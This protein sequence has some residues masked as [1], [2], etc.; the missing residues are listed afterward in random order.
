MKKTRLFLIL[1]TAIGLLAGCGESAGTQNPATTGSTD[2]VKSQPASTTDQTATTTDKSVQP[3]DGS[4]T[5]VP[6]GNTAGNSYTLQDIAQHATPND[7]WMT[8]G[9]K[10]YDVSSYV[11]KHPGGEA[12]LQG[13]GIDATGMFQQVHTGE[14]AGRANGLL[15]NYQ[16]GTLKS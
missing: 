1:I 8:I 10:V 13:C 12:I 14:K 16:V 6:S 11:A 9:G 5:T 4:A 15:D 3:A 2:T 7:C